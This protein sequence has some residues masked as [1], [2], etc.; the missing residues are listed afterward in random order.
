MLNSVNIL[1][2]TF[3]EFMT[4]FLCEIA[5]DKDYYVVIAYHLVKGYRPQLESM[6]HLLS[7]KRMRG[8][9]CAI[10]LVG[11]PASDELVQGYLDHPEPQVVAESLDSL[12]L[13]GVVKWERISHFLVHAS[14]F[15][16]GAALRFARTKLGKD[17]LSLLLAALNDVDEIVR[18]NA[19]DELD[20]IADQSH[21]PLLAPFLQ[22]PSV[23]VRQAA[24]TLIAS[25]GG[26]S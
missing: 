14:P 19:I 24:E 21:I 17:A 15:V 3:E 16:R 9:I 26:N 7:T 4:L 12:R 11:S 13:T 5:N 6:L 25:I 20:G 2:R 10:G 18:Q 1:D 22:D 8:A 23:H